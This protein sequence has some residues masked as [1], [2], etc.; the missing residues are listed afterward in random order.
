MT[1]PLLDVVRQQHAAI[2]W[3]MAKVVSLDPTFMPTTSPIWPAAEAGFAIIDPNVTHPDDDREAVTRFLAPGEGEVLSKH[4][5]DGALAAAKRW[6]KGETSRDAAAMLIERADLFDTIASEVW[7]RS[8]DKRWTFSGEIPED[9]IIPEH[10]QVAGVSIVDAK[11]ER[12]G[13]PVTPGRYR[14][15]GGAIAIVTDIF[16]NEAFYPVLGHDEDSPSRGITWQ[17]NGAFDHQLPNHRLDLVERLPEFVEAVAVEAPAAKLVIEAGRSY[18]TRDG[19]VATMMEHK[20]KRTSLHPWHGTVLGTEGVWTWSNDG[21]FDV[22]LSEHPLDMVD[23]HP[24][25]Q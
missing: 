15:R 11:P 8:E 10:P 16:E 20:P 12:P 24:K 9:P 17:L 14:M 7:L 22:E 3:L 4:N 18:T 5:R 6:V 19:R 13:F 1:A 21:K 25:E 23:T 2:D